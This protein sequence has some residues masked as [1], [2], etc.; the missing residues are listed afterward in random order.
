MEQ[1]LGAHERGCQE[2]Q[3]GSFLNRK[4]IDLLVKALFFQVSVLQLC[5]EVVEVLH[6][7]GVTL[8]LVSKGLLLAF[9]ELVSTLCHVGCI[10]PNLEH[11]GFPFF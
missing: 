4:L 7:L 11:P 3:F 1:V 9:E 6:V 2:F 10:L 5:V 8:F